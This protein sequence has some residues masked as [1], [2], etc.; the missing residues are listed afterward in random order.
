MDYDT[1]RLFDVI[2]CIGVLAHVTSMEKMIFKVSSLLKNGGY[3]VFQITEWRNILNKISNLSVILNNRQS[4]TC[5]YQINKTNRQ[6]VIDIASKAGLEFFMEARYWPLL[7]GMRKLLTYDI[8]FKYQLVTLRN[9][10]I[11]KLGSEI[12]MLFYKE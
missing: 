12:I 5:G 6:E 7:P 8:C 1:N 4:N 10:Y 11:S 2:I 3:C 9:Y